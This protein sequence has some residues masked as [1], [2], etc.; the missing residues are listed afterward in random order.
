MLKPAMQKT[1][2]LM[3]AIAKATTPT[4]NTGITHAAHLT[5]YTTSAKSLLK[6]AGHA[7][8]ANAFHATARHAT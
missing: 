1:A 6:S 3:S 8:M 2:I 7:V 5:A 4:E